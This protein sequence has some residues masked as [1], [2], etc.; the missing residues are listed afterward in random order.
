MIFPRTKDKPPRDRVGWRFSAGRTV[1]SLLSAA[2]LVAVLVGAPGIAQ[3][4]PGDPYVPPSETV[5]T[6]S[7]DD[8]A[9]RNQPPPAV[10]TSEDVPPGATPPSPLPVPATPVGGGRMGECGVVVPVGAPALPSDI[11]AGAW[12]VA[13]LDTG[14]ILG[15]KD[16]HGRYR[17]ASTLK[18]LTAQVMLKNLTN[19]DLP[20][21]GTQ[22]DTAQDGTRVGLEAGGI[23]TVR[24]LLSY[25]VMISG[26]D[27]ANALAR[28]NGGFDKTVA[29]MNATALALGGL[30]TRAATPSG[31]D[32]P[33]QSTSAYDLALFAR[34]D[35]A[36]PPFAE[37]ISA[38]DVRVPGSGNEGYIAAND[39]QLLYQYPGALGGKTGFT[40]D[41]GNTYVGMAE[42][43]GRRLVVTMMNGN[44]VPRRQWM[45]AASLLDWGFAL[46]A[47]TLPVGRLVGSLAEATGL[48]SPTPSTGPPP[49]SGAAGATG[50]AETGADDAAVSSG[51]AAPTTTTTPTT[52][53]LPTAV[54]VLAGIGVLVLILG[55]GLL[56]RR[57]YLNKRAA[58]AGDAKPA[59][60]AAG[61]PAAGD[62]TA[63]DTTAETTAETTTG[64][65]AP[66]D[67]APDDTGRASPG[68]AA[69]AGAVIADQV[70]D[71]PGSAP[72]GTTPAE[73]EGPTS[74]EDGSVSEASERA[75][76]ALSDG[77]SVNPAG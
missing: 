8:C 41:A 34:K 49:A 60:A 62:T 11:S 21:E 63:G 18:L 69:A 27:A 50:S 75:D 9:Q 36:T 29:D 40:D 15:A 7:T 68:A 20:V 58:F 53:G 5:Q 47:T 66:D 42:R 6:P 33:G 22:A 57:R 56:V 32:G 67:T 35:L 26:N 23:Y 12:M 71:A 28:T 14:E 52:G 25:L 72:T 65:T 1:A 3:A 43:N 46:P 64:D 59:E 76:G 30:D 17:P 44:H 4:T 13:D 19:L 39:N 38:Q 77:E 10:D 61:E 24:Q 51:E 37:M 48:P 31:L 45:Q 73:A 74:H 2:A 54:I 70:A 55:V 16:P